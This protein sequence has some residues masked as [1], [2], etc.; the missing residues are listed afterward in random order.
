MDEKIVRNSL[1]LTTE[2]L[3]AIVDAKNGK[4]LSEEEQASARTGLNKVRELE[5]HVQCRIITKTKKKE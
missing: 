1:F 3:G 2:E 4:V 5:R